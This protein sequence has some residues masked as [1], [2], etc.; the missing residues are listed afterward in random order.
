MKLSFGVVSAALIANITFALCQSSPNWRGGEIQRP[1]EWAM[2]GAAAKNARRVDIDDYRSGADRNDCAAFQRAHDANAGA[3]IYVPARLLIMDDA[4]HPCATAI[5][6]EVVI[7]GSGWNETHASGSVLSFVNPLSQFRVSGTSARGFTL[8]NLS[9]KQSHPTIGAGWTPTTYLPVV[10]ATGTAG[11]ITIDNVLCAPCYDLVS[12]TSSG[13]LFV[14]DVR[15]QIFHRAIYADQSYDSDRYMNVHVWPY[16]SNDVN[17]LAWQ[18]ANLNVIELGR[19]DTPF[20]DDVFAMAARSVLHTVSTASGNASK[21]LAGSLACDACQYGLLV[22]S[23]NLSAI[24]ASLMHQGQAAV[25]DGAPLAGTRAIAGSGSGAR[26]TIGGVIGERYDANVLTMPGVSNIVIIGNAHINLANQNNIRA[27]I[28]GPLGAD[29]SVQFSVPPTIEGSNS[30]TCGACVVGMQQNT[31]ANQVNE[32]RAF[33][34]AVGGGAMLRAI[35]AD[36]NVSIM[37]D[38]KGNQR[39]QLSA[40]AKA[41]FAVDDFAGNGDTSV[42]LRT[43]VGSSTLFLESAQANAD[44]ILNAKGAGVIRVGTRT[45]GDNSTAVAS[46][47]YVDRAAGK[48]IQ[49]G[50]PKSSSEACV[51]GAEMADAHFVYFC[52]ATNVW[53]RAALSAF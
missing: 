22:D 42:L 28:I 16:W 19:V 20:I 3:T 7:Q 41:I 40:N 6:N 29:S 26:L 34:A 49:F 17:V 53:K 1:A 51:Q 5:T 30:A 45:A 2:R 9:I 21:V 44:L 13:R 10:A 15:G 52:T 14:S 31:V 24:I 11:Q 25:G 39:S 47:A 18:Q 38:A 12:A 48:T 43:G 32:V 27:S 4:A 8:R 33:G 46:T 23:D 36:P 35:G 37:L 50:T